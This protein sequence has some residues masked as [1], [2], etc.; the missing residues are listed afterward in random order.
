MAKKPSSDTP[1]KMTAKAGG[2]YDCGACGWALVPGK[3]PETLTCGNPDCEQFEKLYQKPVV[4]LVPYEAP[5][6]E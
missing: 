4:E 1:T 5:A 3:P 6:S 2:N